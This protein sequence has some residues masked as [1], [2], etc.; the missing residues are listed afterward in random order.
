MEARLKLNVVFTGICS[1]LRNEQRVLFPNATRSRKTCDGS[2]LPIHRT[3]I[4]YSIDDDQMQTPFDITNGKGLA[5]I[6][7]NGEDIIIRGTPVTTTTT[8][9]QI[10][11]VA[12]MG[13]IFP[14]LTLDPKFLNV[15]DKLS[16]VDISASFTL[17]GGKF[18]TPNPNAKRIW[19][20]FPQKGAPI[21]G[22]LAQVVT[23]SIELKED[24]CV[25]ALKPFGAA[26][27]AV[28]ILDLKSDS[29]AVDILIGNTPPD[30]GTIFP[31]DTTK[32]PPLGPDPHFEIYYRMA[33]NPG[34]CPFPIPHY[35]GE[36]GITKVHAH[37][38]SDCH[39]AHEPAVAK[40]PVATFASSL[41]SFDSLGGAN[42]P[43]NQWP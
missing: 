19:H 13:A 17:A 26:T 5:A 32:Q 43:P 12:S 2:V 28:D 30:Q 11:K 38:A 40:R 15:P 33:M 21:Q 23:Y 31:V 10:D 24:N 39:E 8:P 42:C 37:G 41:S 27:T 9:G 3:Y 6:F 29:V 1:I 22:P 18:Q 16:P 35:E 7:V 25:I 36:A 34:T 20:F 4:R 14:G